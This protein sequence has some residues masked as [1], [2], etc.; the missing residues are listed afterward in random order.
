VKAG[1]DAGKLEKVS[2]PTEEAGGTGDPPVEGGRGQPDERVPVGPQDA[3]EQRVSSKMDA[4]REEY[5]DQQ[6][7]F[8][9]AEAC[10]VTSRY[11]RDARPHGHEGSSR[12][13]R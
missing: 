1:D 10:A 4:R 12:T 8:L 9:W 3:A 5:L 11:G 6:H 2:P 7:G 13:G